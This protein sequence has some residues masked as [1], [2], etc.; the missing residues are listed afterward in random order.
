MFDK[1][2]NFNYPLLLKSKNA[3]DSFLRIELYLSVKFGKF[4]TELTKIPCSKMKEFCLIPDN[5]LKFLLYY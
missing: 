2:A 5:D 3:Y 1:V 4:K